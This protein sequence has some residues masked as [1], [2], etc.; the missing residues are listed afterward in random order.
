M[1]GDKY[2]WR[3]PRSAKQSRTP[4]ARS[5]SKPKRNWM[6]YV[7]DGGRGFSGIGS[8]RAEVQRS[9]PS[10]SAQAYRVR[11]RQFASNHGVFAPGGCP[12]A[13]PRPHSVTPSSHE[14]ARATRL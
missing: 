7:A 4:M 1:H 9:C 12:S 3:T 2:T 14:L 6:R 11:A 5:K 10:E 8:V 13:R